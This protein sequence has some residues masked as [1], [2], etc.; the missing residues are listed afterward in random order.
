MA[1]YYG[2]TVSDGGKVTNME[3]VQKIIEKYK[4]GTEGELS[5]ELNGDELNVYGYDEPYAYL[6]EDEDYENEV[7]DNFLEEVAPYIVDTFIVQSCGNE[8]C[9]YISA[10]AYIV[11]D[12]KVVCTSLEEAIN[13]KINTI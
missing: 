7:F 9:R 5:V 1:N 10:Y 12:K 6:V 3:E 2:T 4:F 8:K 11:K 13:N